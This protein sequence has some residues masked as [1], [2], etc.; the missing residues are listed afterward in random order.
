[1]KEFTKRCR[2]LYRTVVKERQ[3]RI[4]KAYNLWRKCR[5]AAIQSTSPNLNS[6][7]EVAKSAWQKLTSQS[8]KRNEAAA[9]DRHFDL[10]KK[11]SREFFWQSHR[12]HKWTN[13]SGVEL[14]DGTVTNDTQNIQTK[15]IRYW[16]ALFSSKGK[17]P[18]KPPTPSLM[19]DI[20]NKIH[21]TLMGHQTLQLDRAIFEEETLRV[22]QTLPLHKE[23]GPDDLRGEF[24]R[25]SAVTWVKVTARIINDFPTQPPHPPHVSQTRSSPSSTRMAPRIKSKIIDP[26]LW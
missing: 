21:T 15:N 4:T 23:E 22:I 17:E 13:I 18:K 6:D 26:Q 2:V 1:M 7:A 10:Y 19:T 20:I 16:K 5:F 12:T 9:S 3:N 24:F 25:A 14:A 11:P 8:E